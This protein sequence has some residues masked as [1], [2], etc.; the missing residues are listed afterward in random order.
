MVWTKSRPSSVTLTL[1]LPEQIFQMAHLHEM[2][3]SGVKFF[4][5]PSTIVEVMAWTNSDTHLHQT[6]VVTTV[7]RSAH[8]KWAGQK[9]TKTWKNTYLNIKLQESV[10]NG[11]CTKK[12][13]WF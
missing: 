9:C 3:N 11:P 6:V 1:G 4:C 12:K 5:N 2:E 7:P 13:F 8:C 10:M